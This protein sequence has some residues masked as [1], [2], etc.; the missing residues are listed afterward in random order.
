MINVL[1]VAGLPGSGKTTVARIIERRGYLYYSLG[2]VVRAEAERRGLTPDKTAVTMRLERG[3]KAVIYELLKSVKPGEK[4]VIDGIRSI[5]EVEALEEFL[6]TV[7]LIYVVAS[8]KV[9]YQRLTGRGRSD[10]PLSFSQF[11]LRDLRELRFGLADLLSRADY[12]IVNE[13][14]SIEELEQEIGKVLLELR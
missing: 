6:G 1:A 14:K 5:E 7:F 8:R 4:V 9:R 11:L 13:T 3:R 10:D 12:I 2:D